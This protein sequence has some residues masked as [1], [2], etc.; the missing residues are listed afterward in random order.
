MV[1]QDRNWFRQNFIMPLVSPPDWRKKILEGKKRVNAIQKAASKKDPSA[2]PA[3]IEALE[4]SD[5]QVRWHAGEAL[6]KIG[7]PSAV[8][9]LAERLKNKDWVIRLQAA[10]GLGNIGHASAVPA[11]IESLN[12]QNIPVREQVM[13]ALG[14][15]GEPAIAPLIQLLRDRGDDIHGLAL[16]RIGKPAIP[17]LM[18]LT[19]AEEYFWVRTSAVISLERIGEPAF[20]S[21]VAL[22]GRQRLGINSARAIAGILEKCEEIKKLEDFEKLLI[23]RAAEL[24]KMN[25]TARIN[26]QTEIAMLLKRI[27]EK[28]NRVSSRRGLL[29]PDTIKPPTKNKA[30]YMALKRAISPLR[31]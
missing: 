4:H 17:A 15:I 22:L 24:R 12:D 3:L 23:E 20:P 2:V 21:L 14:R 11:L 18:K 8:P 6:G 16:A 28:K 31:R 25:R 13:Q 29:L 1:G 26:G 10:E 27:A 7:H 5:K 30:V 9:A 19:S